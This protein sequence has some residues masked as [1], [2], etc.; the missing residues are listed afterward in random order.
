MSV[1]LPNTAWI[2]PGYPV[3]GPPLGD[4]DNILFIVVHYGGVPWPESKLANSVQYW[5]DTQRYY[6]DGRGYSIGYQEGTGRDGSEW[7]LRGRTLR[8]A[9]NS[10]TWT[11]S[12]YFATWVRNTPK[13]VIDATGKPNPNYCTYSLHVILPM[14]G[15]LA[16][17]QLEGIR[18]AILKIWTWLGRMV[19]VIPHSDVVRTSCPG[20]PIRALIK[21]GAIYPQPAPVPTPPPTPQ[22]PTSTRKHSVNSLTIFDSVRVLDTRNAPNTKPGT[23]AVV[24]VTPVAGTPAGASVI[25]H[26]TTTDTSDDGFLTLWSGDGPRP[27]ASHLNPKRNDVRN[28]GAVIVPLGKDGRF[29]I[30]TERPTHIIVDQA[31]YFA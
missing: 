7:E 17:G 2:E 14:D 15:K 27:L 6:V 8:N 30:Y 19:P 23:G 5:R 12:P 21:S 1:R 16:P 3:T 22:L 4:K 29:S 11:G 31:G 25:V 26:V 9:A 20:D 13:H 28:A 24:K 10:S 18:S